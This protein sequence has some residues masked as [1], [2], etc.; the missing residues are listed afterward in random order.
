VGPP[1]EWQADAKIE[2]GCFA[3]SSKLESAA[4]VTQHVSWQ[5][6]SSVELVFLNGD[7]DGIT[8][9]ASSATHPFLLD[10]EWVLSEAQAKR[11]NEIFRAHGYTALELPTRTFG[12]GDVRGWLVPSA[13]VRWTRKRVPLGPNAVSELEDAI[14]VRCGERGQ[15]YVTVLE[16]SWAEHSQAATGQAVQIPGT[17]WMVITAE[18]EWG[19]EGEYGSAFEAAL[20]DLEACGKAPARLPKRVGE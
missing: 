14:E 18:Y 9:Q 17:H 11:A 13:S 15:P 1:V 2:P 4:C 10:G 3:W 12:P 5:D 8:L 7:D 19:L 16:P 20:V 6:E